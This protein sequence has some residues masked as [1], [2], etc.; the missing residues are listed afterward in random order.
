VTGL[1]AGVLTLVSGVL[2]AVALSLWSARRR[3]KHTIRLPLSMVVILDEDGAVQWI[4][5]GSVRREHAEALAERE[6]AKG[7]RAIVADLRQVSP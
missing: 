2:L 7:R 4:A 6:R 1:E 3:Q 5:C